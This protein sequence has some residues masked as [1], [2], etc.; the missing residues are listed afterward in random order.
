MFN[1]TFDASGVKAIIGRVE[2]V[3]TLAQNSAN[4]EQKYT[5]GENC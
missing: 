1:T 2:G 5:S 4:A 3:K